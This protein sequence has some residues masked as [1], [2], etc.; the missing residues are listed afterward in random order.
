MVVNLLE[1]TTESNSLAQILTLHAQIMFELCQA[2]ES[3]DGEDSKAILR[4]LQRFEGNSS[5]ISF[6]LRRELVQV[7]REPIR[8]DLT[9]EKIAKRSEGFSKF[10]AA[11]GL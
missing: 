11:G 6:V 4:H 5:A 3:Y 7:Y 8:K 1:L 10:L 2:I 9:V